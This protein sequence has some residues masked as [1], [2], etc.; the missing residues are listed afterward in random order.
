LL[1][2]AIGE[3]VPDEVKLQQLSRAMYNEDKEKGKKEFSKVLASLSPDVVS[4]TALCNGS[5][6]RDAVVEEKTDFIRLLLEHGV[7]PTIGTD[8]ATMWTPVQI[9]AE[10]ASEDSKKSEMLT[11]LAEYAPNPAGTKAKLLKLIIESDGQ[12]E[13][14]LE[15]FKQQLELLS[16]SEV[17]QI[18]ISGDGNL[19]HFA[20]IKDLKE[21]VRILLQ[22]GCD[23]KVPMA[24]YNDRS[25]LETAVD[26]GRMEIW[27]LMREGLELTEREKLEQLCR[28]IVA[29]KMEEDDPWKEFKDLL[30]SLPVESVN[31]TWVF[32]KGSSHMNR[33]LLQVAA[34]HD[35]KRA[36]RVLLEY[37]VR[38][39][40]SELQD[41]VIESNIYFV[42]LLQEYGVDVKAISG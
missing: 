2:E 34:A 41:S 21:H 13:A 30:S 38:P 36:V 29:G 8:N 5:I 12:Q 3:E 17:D 15:D 31:T 10:M 37:G 9:A 1:F 42:R 24:A 20:V 7:D 23:P 33:R 22:H 16:G 40:G 35:N 14:F 25:P 4:S 19:L 6:L 32:A 18:D 39:T 26:N 28:M 11:L 27:N